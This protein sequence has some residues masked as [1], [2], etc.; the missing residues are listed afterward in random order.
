TGSNFDFNSL[1]PL[2]LV[3]VVGGLGALTLTR[4]RKNA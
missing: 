2:G 1:L 4:K 3:L